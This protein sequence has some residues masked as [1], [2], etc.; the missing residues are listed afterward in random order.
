MYLISYHSQ[1]R[2]PYILKKGKTK[3]CFIYF[4]LGSSLTV[5]K[6]GSFGPLSSWS[7]WTFVPM[8][9]SS[10]I[11]FFH[12]FFLWGWFKSWFLYSV[13]WAIWLRFGPH[14]KSNNG[15]LSKVCSFFCKHKI[16]KTWISADISFIYYEY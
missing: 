16:S 3:E 5:V 11:C 9:I 6:I 4:C 1:N 12:T 15:E 13:S 10:P 2:W 14:G 7:T 8:K